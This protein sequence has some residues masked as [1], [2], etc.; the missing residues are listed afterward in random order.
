MR[1]FHFLVLAISSFVLIQGCASYTKP[2]CDES[3]R[4]DIP[5]FEGQFSTSYSMVLP[6]GSMIIRSDYSISRVARGTY[7]LESREHTIH[8]GICEI[9]GQYYAENDAG[10]GLSFPMGPGFVAF[11]V[12]PN[13]NG[14]F[15]M[16]GL[17]IDTKVLDAQKVPYTITEVK[18]SAF[19]KDD[20]KQSNFYQ[21]LV[22]NKG[23]SPELFAQMLDPISFKFTLLPQSP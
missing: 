2:I 19:G 22:D 7:I 20:P 11:Q 15:D 16:I 10:W 3:N 23:I 18:M 13:G 1:N 17:G 14:S 12:S 5:N 6:T 8:A 4:K 21:L 9:E